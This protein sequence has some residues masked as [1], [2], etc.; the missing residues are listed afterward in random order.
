[1]ILEK[2]VLST[3]SVVRGGAISFEISL[4]HFDE[5]A[6]ALERLRLGAVVGIAICA[7]NGFFGACG[8]YGWVRS[9]ERN[10]SM[11]GRTEDQ[12][13]VYKQYFSARDFNAM[14]SNK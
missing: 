7:V 5:G 14:Q 2:E 13:S 4:E 9:E 8:I 1:L 12:L 10:E 6:F 11:D 3:R